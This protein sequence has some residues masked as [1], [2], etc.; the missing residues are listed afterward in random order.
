[1][2]FPKLLYTLLLCCIT[3]FGFTQT[4]PIEFNNIQF[5][6]LDK[7]TGLPNDMVW[8]V[9]QDSK[10][11]MWIGTHNGLTRWDGLNFKYFLPNPIDSTAIMGTSIMD[12][13][14]D[15]DG[16]LWFLV[17]NKGLSRFDPVTE[18]F[19]N[20]RH[21]PY[22]KGLMRM[23]N[24]EDGYLWL[25]AY[26]SGMFRYEIATDN[27]TRLPLKAHFDDDEDLFRL[28]SI[29]DIVED[30]ENNNILWCAGNNGLFRFDRTTLDY[31]YF[32]SPA[33]GTALMTINGVF[34]D[35][36]NSLWMG[37]WGG[38]LI[39]FDIPTAK[40][41]YHTYDKPNMLNYDGL[42]YSDIAKSILRKSPTELWVQTRDRGAG[43]YDIKND[44]FLFFKHEITNPVS[45]K[46]GTGNRLFEDKEGRIWFTFE[47]A[48]LSY[49]NPECQ[50]FFNM[51]LN[52][53]SCE[54]T[55]SENNVTDFGYDANTDK[56]YAVANGC[57]GL[58]EI[59]PED[60]SYKAIP[61][62]GLENE[63]QIFMTNLVTQDGQVWVGGESDKGD[64]RKEV[65]RPSLLYLDKQIGK[66]VPFTHPVIEEFKLQQRNIRDIQ[67]GKN[68]IIWVATNDGTLVEIN[69]AEDKVQADSLITKD[70]S[71]LQ[72]RQIMPES[73]RILVA[74]SKGLYTFDLD[75]RT[76]QLL[77]TSANFEINAF[78]KDKNGDL[79]FGTMRQGLK[80]M[81][82]GS[83]EIITPDAGNL[84]YTLID[85]VVVD[86]DNGLWLST[87]DGL[88]FLDKSVKTHTEGNF[89]VYNKQ[90]GLVFN[91]FYLHGFTA[92]PDG[93]LLLG[94]NDKYYHIRP[95]CLRDPKTITPVYLTSFQILGQTTPTPIQELK[96]IELGPDE[97]FFNIHFSS[98]TY[99]QA[100]KVRFTYKMEGLDKDWITTNP[101]QSHQNYTKLD[102]GIYTFRIHRTG[103]SE[104]EQR[105]EITIHP[106]IWLSTGAYL[107]YFLIG[108]GGL[109]SI[110]HF[111]LKK[112]RIEQE[113]KN[114]KEIDAVKNKTY[115]DI[116]HEIRSPLTLIMGFSEQIES[117]QLGDLVNRKIAGIK[118]NGNRILHLVNQILDLGKLET[119][120]F[121]LN[122]IQKE[123]TGLLKHVGYNFEPILLDKGI[124]LEK[125][126]G[127]SS[128]IM[129][130]DPDNLYSIL[131][132]LLDNAIKF[133]PSGG[134]IKY[135]ANRVDDQ[136]IIEVSDTG[137]GIAKENLSKVF[138]RYVGEN[139]PSYTS[140][141]IGLS[142]TKALVE[143]MGGQIKVS[144]ELGKGSVFKVI[145][146]ITNK[147]PKAAYI[148]NNSVNGNPKIIAKPISLLEQPID[149]ES[150]KP[151]VLIIEDNLEI[152]N[153]VASILT[154]G[155]QIAHAADGQSGINKAIEML[156]DLIISDVMMP[157]KD[158]FEVCRTLKENQLSSHI[159]IILLT[160][161]VEQAAKIKGIKGGADTYLTK[162]F[163]T[164][165]LLVWVDNLLN[166]RK[167]L[168]DRYTNF[169]EMLPSTDK[170]EQSGFIIEGLDIDMQDSFVKELCYHFEKNIADPNYASGTI[171][172]DLN[173]SKSQVYRKVKALTNLSPGNFLRLYRLSKAK[174][175]LT[176]TDMNITEVAYETGFQDSSY[177]TRAFKE[178]FNQTPTEVKETTTKIERKG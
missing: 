49:I 55:F 77:E 155:Y 42:G 3:T 120:Q 121:K 99:C 47:D 122:I 118:N 14:E 108:L 123:V 30:V 38:G 170:K 5:N 1:M 27:L 35:E 143:L 176:T 169:T 107:L 26:G 81:A 125:S 132:N 69:T 18:R 23:K 43:I 78:A 135:S 22:L 50:A 13:E 160:A 98:L 68:G 164:D 34:M 51:P 131:S 9:F 134:I 46:P 44:T 2:P 101:G 112:Q 62:M 54:K 20:F 61:T 165:E 59:S 60:W 16:Y 153:L 73:N 147:A 80:K 100:D 67:E 52:L 91:N 127:F 37:A 128:L 175:L 152:A 161:K 159:P 142:L 110:Y 150:D 31:K 79:W 76:F 148:L 33:K 172:L 174:I 106:P 87:Q 144:S 126:I 24:F 57:N 45:I 90:D 133:T 25:A 92:L 53:K 145:L 32:Q 115:T 154:S 85:K 114:L 8:K 41:K 139:I 141:G 10:G 95:D 138:D 113:A 163:A 58:F 102:A 17:H 71:K 88:Y 7:K 29:V 70:S 136:L 19:T 168:K 151:I 21:E 63:Y 28:N 117:L 162:P 130:H 84:P 6:H 167:A 149:K 109:Y 64:K 72:I 40:W 166:S 12:I 65:K 137:K 36:P 93:T 156:P 140:T 105:L 83:N 39:H 173:L 94:Q 96:K 177:F 11:F 119:K 171:H 157:K 146:P 75:S 124:K 74:T 97:N 158:G 103:F 129:D 89:K 116:S 56:I 178:A 104:D 86:K 15:K 111:Q 4:N 82:N 66:L 48:G